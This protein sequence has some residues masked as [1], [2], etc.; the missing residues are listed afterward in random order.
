MIFINYES[1]L[2]L[3]VSLWVGVYCVCGCVC[4]CV[5]T[6]GMRGVMIVLAGDFGLNSSCSARKKVDE[7]QACT[8]S[9]GMSGV[10]VRNAA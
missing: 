1:P 9:C 4:V 2:G 6:S 3:V 5:C 7:L 10:K 8:K